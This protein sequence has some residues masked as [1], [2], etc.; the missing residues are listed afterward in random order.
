MQTGK[1]S[2]ADGAQ[3]SPIALVATGRPLRPGRLGLADRPCC[4]Q[5]I[6]L[7]ATWDIFSRNLLLPAARPSGINLQ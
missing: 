3:L 1:I 5:R 2:A 7:L 4:H 6:A